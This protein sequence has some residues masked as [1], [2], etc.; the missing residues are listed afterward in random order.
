MLKTRFKFLFYTSTVKRWSHCSLHISVNTYVWPAF[1][2]CSVTPLANHLKCLKVDQGRIFGLH[3]FSSDSAWFAT[4]YQC[5]G[6]SFNKLNSALTN[7]LKCI[8]MFRDHKGSSRSGVM[9]LN[10]LKNVKLLWFPC[11]NFS[12]ETL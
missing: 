11:S 10:K 3:F 5:F 7:H 8:H 4:N 1:G 2:F 12:L 9:L 6:F